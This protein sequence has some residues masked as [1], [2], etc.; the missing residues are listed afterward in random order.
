MTA[1][2]SDIQYPEDES[3]AFAA[4]ENDFCSG[5]LFVTAQFFAGFKEVLLGCSQQ[6]P[7]CLPILPNPQSIA[8]RDA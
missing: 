2:L 3:K 5:W 8:Q 1:S 7:Q 6:M 4:G